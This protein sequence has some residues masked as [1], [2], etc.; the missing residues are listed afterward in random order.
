MT[1][2]LGLARSFRMAAET[3]AALGVLVGALSLG[4]VAHA[5]CP[6]APHP[7]LTAN[8]TYYVWDCARRLTMVISPTTGTGSQVA[9]QYIYDADSQLL[10]TDKATV[11]SPYGSGFS[12]LETTTYLYD[13]GGNKVQTNVL[14]GGPSAMTLLAITNN[15]YDAD[16]RATCSAVRMNLGVT[17]PSSACTQGTA[18]PTFGPDLITQTVYCD[19]GV[20]ALAPTCAVGKTY[21]ELR[22]VGTPLVQTYQTITYTSD[23]KPASI[24]D[25]RNN[26][27]SMT[28]DG[29]DRLITTTFADATTEKNQY[30]LNGNVLA[31]TNRGA[32]TVV[33]G[34]DNLNRKICEEGLTGATV[35]GPAGSP[36]TAHDWAAKVTSAAATSH[37]GRLHK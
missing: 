11:T 16:D 36:A 27:F 30:D 7:T 22:A 21:Q 14:N 20:G 3:L 9:T 4:G 33:R 31:W 17:P 8:T 25:A 10:E 23:G 1:S 15:S 37:H 28:Y 29:Y 18:S 2:T 6:T 24:T 13:A 26:A 12:A 32:F 35:T 5:A 19:G 34:Y